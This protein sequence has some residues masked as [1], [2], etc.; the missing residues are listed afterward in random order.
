VVLIYPVLLR[1]AFS[2]FDD[3]SPSANRYLSQAHDALLQGDFALAK[4]MAEDALK[5]NPR[6]Y[7]AHNALG[8]CFGVLS[9]YIGALACFDASLNIQPNQTEANINRVATLEMLGKQLN[10]KP[11]D[12]ESMSAFG[13]E[14]MG[15][16]IFV[17]G[18]DNN[19]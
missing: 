12:P 10:L 4:T 18:D 13:D 17:R 14:T 1:K 5:L 2:M 16:A 15:C 3:N 11:L 7:Q 9:D 6:S 8:I 19:D